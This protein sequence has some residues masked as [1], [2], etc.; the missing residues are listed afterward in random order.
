MNSRIIL[1]MGVVV[2][3]LLVGVGI[4]LIP[5]KDDPSDPLT[6]VDKRGDGVQEIVVQRATE[7]QSFYDDLGQQVRT[8]KIKTVF[9]LH[10]LYKGVEF[11][12]EYVD[13]TGILRA[14][15]SP[16]M[17]PYD[18]V[19]EAYILIKFVDE[20]PY[21]H[22]FL[23]EDFRTQIDPVNIIWGSEYQNIKAYNYT[24]ISKGVYM[25]V[26]KDEKSRH[27][28]DYTS[29]EGGVIVGDLTIEDIDEENFDHT[30]LVRLY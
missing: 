29:S 15:I 24:L 8:D 21:A 30:T 5:P 12:R 23:D 26:I 7:G 14:S 10:G 3:L 17:M 27:S 6:W 16:E 2:V 25:D 22:I 20:Q 13:E 19:I 1:I 11:E 4:M 28:E 9:D 18:G